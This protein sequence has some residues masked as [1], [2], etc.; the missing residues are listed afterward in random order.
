M[1]PAYLVDSNVVLGIVKDDPTWVSW[2]AQAL[3]E[4]SLKGGVAINPIILAEISVG[5]FNRDVFE[6]TMFPDRFLRLAL[7]WEAAWIA[8]KAFVDY[9]HRGGPDLL[10]YQISTSAPM[11]K[12]P[13]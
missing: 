3:A 8:G 11:T 7:P 1:R 2:S 9:R 4:A 5:F 6:Q 13:D 12:F 10:R